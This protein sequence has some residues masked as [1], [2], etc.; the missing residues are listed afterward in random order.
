MHLCCGRSFS[1]SAHFLY[2]L[3][4]ITQVVMRHLNR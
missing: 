1:L 2:E 4:K 3:M